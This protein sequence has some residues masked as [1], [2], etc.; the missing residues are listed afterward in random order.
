[1]NKWQLQPFSQRTKSQGLCSFD[2]GVCTYTYLLT[3][4]LGVVTQYN[5]GRH[6][7]QGTFLRSP[8]GHA[9]NQA[10]IV[11]KTLWFILFLF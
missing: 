6:H 4:D 8:D 9:L 11:S 5:S 2:V 7:K 1:M 3:V 10:K